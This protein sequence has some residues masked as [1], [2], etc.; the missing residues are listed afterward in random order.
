MSS[1]TYSLTLIRTAMILSRATSWLR[2]SVH[3]ARSLSPTASSRASGGLFAPLLCPFCGL[4]ALSR[5]HTSVSDRV[6]AIGRML[7]HNKDGQVSLDE[8]VDAIINAELARPRVAHPRLS[9]AE[10]HTLSSPIME[11]APG[12]STRFKSATGISVTPLLRC[13]HS[14]RRAAVKPP[15]PPPVFRVQRAG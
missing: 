4:L 12:G 2:L 13:S 11:L 8:F 9:S 10:A 7:D 15:Q 1:R 14:S 6:D 3:V 5:L